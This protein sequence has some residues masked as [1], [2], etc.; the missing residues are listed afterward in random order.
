MPVTQQMKS[1][2]VTKVPTYS[3]VRRCFGENVVSIF[4]LE[5]FDLITNER[6]I[7][8]HS[9]FMSGFGIFLPLYS[10]VSEQRS[11]EIEVI[12]CHDRFILLGGRWSDSGGSRSTVGAL[13]CRRHLG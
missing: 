5:P 13:C 4:P 2:P 8:A 6:G 10:R 9:P 11:D 7:H 12:S 1:C 3:F